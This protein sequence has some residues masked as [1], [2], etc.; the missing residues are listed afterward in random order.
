MDCKGH[1]ATTAPV[2]QTFHHMQATIRRKLNDGNKRLPDTIT[3]DTTYNNNAKKIKSHELKHQVKH[4]CRH[5][6][7]ELTKNEITIT[8]RY[9]KVLP[10]DIHIHISYYKPSICNRQT[11][12]TQ[13]IRPQTATS[14]LAD[15]SLVPN[16]FAA[17]V[18]THVPTQ[19]LIVVRV[20]YR[21]TLPFCRLDL[22]KQKHNLL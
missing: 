8:S 19:E 7:K 5:S 13:P 15:T 4:G 22:T 6:R 17:V 1:D 16:S 2:L 9:R 11:K 18:Y 12:P 10:I 3:I 20:I 21:P 14:I